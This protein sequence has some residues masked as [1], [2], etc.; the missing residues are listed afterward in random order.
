MGIPTAFLGSLLLLPAVDVSINMI[1]MFAFIVALGIVVDDAIIAGENIYEHM[2]QGMPFA[3]A[4][5]VGAREVAS[6]LAFAIL[7]NVA[8]F[9]PLLALPGMMGKLFLA[10]PIVVISCFLISWLE[11]LFILPSHLAHLKEKPESRLGR[12]LDAIQ[13]AVDGQL[14]RFI[15]RVYRPLLGRS[16]RNPD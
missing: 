12:K 10:I 5:V 7:T 14:G 4:A 13:E 2:Q 15:E 16:L 1:S 8:A 3:D 9:L 6:P 11:A